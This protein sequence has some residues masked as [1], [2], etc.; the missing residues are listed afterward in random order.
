MISAL[1]NYFDCS[2]EVFYRL[3]KGKTFK[4][5]YDQ[6]MELPEEEKKIHGEAHIEEWGLRQ[7]ASQ[8][9]SRARQI[10]DEEM[11]TFY[12][13]LDIGIQYQSMAK[14][15]ELNVKTVKCWKEKSNRAKTYDKY[16]A[17]PEDDRILYQEKAR[18][19]FLP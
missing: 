2:K 8:A 6:F 16:L 3:R 10:T 12:G 11:F 17:L 19:I 7:F 9:G 13:G 18:A 14:I 1:T 15:W 5:V 4:H